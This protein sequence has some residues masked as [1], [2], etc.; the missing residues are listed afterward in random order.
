MAA[1]DMPA[2]DDALWAR[3]LAEDVE[4]VELRAKAGGL[5]EALG[6]SP[7][8]LRLLAEGCCGVGP[9]V[10]FAGLAA[11]RV[12][13]LTLSSAELASFA[14]ER[15][16]VLMD[17]NLSMNQLT[18]V[19]R[20]S[21]AP[22]LSRLDLSYNEGIDV[23]AADCWSGLGE[24]RTLVLEGCRLSALVPSATH[25]AGLT[26]LAGCAPC[27]PSPS[28][29]RPSAQPRTTRGNSAHGCSSSVPRCAG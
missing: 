22:H 9:H 19:P 25:L 28:S 1:N 6:S 29:M 12:L 2:L 13:A 20:L 17:L 4:A 11:E 23:C 3:V 18:V 21:F 26:R 10:R 16:C 8:L 24:L 14:L 5:D 27:R 15:P 7:G